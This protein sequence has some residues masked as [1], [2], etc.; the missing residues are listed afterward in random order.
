MSRAFFGSLER[1]SWSGRGGSEGG[2]EPACCWN[3]NRTMD[4][5]MA[6]SHG[7]GFVSFK[8][9]APDAWESFYVV[10]SQQAK[11][12]LRLVPFGV[13]IGMVRVVLSEMTMRMVGA[14]VE[15]GEEVVV[16]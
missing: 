14:M 1:R 13:G 5:E 16:V 9:E 7:F 6:R 15:S 2:R 3:Q 10:E 11:H 4:K 12:S 8:A